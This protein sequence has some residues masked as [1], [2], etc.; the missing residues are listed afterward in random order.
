[1]E[2]LHAMLAYDFLTVDDDELVLGDELIL[3]SLLSALC[4][5]ESVFESAKTQ[6][7]FVII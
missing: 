6:F 1:M 7:F 3:S 4:F 5:N 2:L